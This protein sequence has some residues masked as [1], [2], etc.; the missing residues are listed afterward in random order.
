MATDSAQTLHA[1]ELRAER[2]IVQEL[3]IMVGEVL[4]LRPCLGIEDRTYADGLLMKLDRLILDQSVP[5]QCSNADAIH[6]VVLPTL[7][8]AV[9]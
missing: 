5:F 3:R 6:I 4:A 8:R 2:A 1:I 9:A 7:A